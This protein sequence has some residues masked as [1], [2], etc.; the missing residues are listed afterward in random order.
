LNELTTQLVFYEE[1]T[2]YR[3]TIKLR[4]STVSVYISCQVLHGVLMRSA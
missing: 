3:L 1:K 2:V 4:E